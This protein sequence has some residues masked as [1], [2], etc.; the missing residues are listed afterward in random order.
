MVKKKMGG[1]QRFKA[2]AKAKS[3]GKEPSEVWKGRGPQPPK[4]VKRKI[5][6]KVEF[7][8]RIAK[9]SLTSKGGIQ[10]KKAHSKQKQID[11]SSLSGNLEIIAKKQ[12][13][14]FKV[15]AKRIRM[16]SGAKHLKLES[17]P[18]ASTSREARRPFGESVGTNAVRR[19]IL[20]KETERLQQVVS[21]P[22]YKSDP[23]A[24]ITNHLS[25]TIPEHKSSEKVGVK[26]KK[27]K[28]QK[29]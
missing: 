3:E 29:S 2:A 13:P 12:S 14:G 8:E 16:N 6:K 26:Q 20:E 23:I 1:G 22:V 19:I 5:S 21:H 17:E 7:L 10:K 4:H 25:R 18:E 11:L 15:G 28:K 9:S 24:A 27:M